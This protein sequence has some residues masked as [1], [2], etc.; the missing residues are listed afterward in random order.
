MRGNFGESGHLV[1]RRRAWG[2]RFPVPEGP[3]V[4][5]FPIH[6]RIGH[7]Q[8]RRADGHGRAALAPPGVVL[9][10]VVVMSD[11]DG[12]PCYYSGG[13]RIHVCSR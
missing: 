12:S 4:F 1:A 8:E 10:F 6:D 7:V 5:D 13:T 2:F 3:G 11:T 9:R